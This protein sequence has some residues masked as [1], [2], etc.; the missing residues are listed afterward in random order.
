[1]P[2]VNVYVV[3]HGE[4]IENAQGIIQGQLDTKLND[5]GRAQ[6]I[7]VGEVLSSIQF[8]YAFTSDLSRA[9]DVCFMTMTHF[10]I[11]SNAILS[12]V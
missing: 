1:M 7:R 6:A 2:V 4:T 3:R 8:H 12:S 5:L 9:R 11:T 10:I